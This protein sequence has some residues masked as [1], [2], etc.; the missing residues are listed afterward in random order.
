MQNILIWSDHKTHKTQR[1]WKVHSGNT[2]I[3]YELKENTKIK[4]TMAINFT[5]SRDSDKIH[6]M[7]PKSNNIENMMS[8]E[9]E[10]IIE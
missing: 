5:S 2:V 8:N 9:A 1:E 7:R 4:L 3:V 10:E 6:T